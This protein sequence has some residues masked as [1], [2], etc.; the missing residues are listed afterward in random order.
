MCDIPYIHKSAGHFYQNQ[1][2]KDMSKTNL[3]F[4][5]IYEDILHI[6]IQIHIL[7]LSRYSLKQV[8]V[9]VDLQSIYKSIF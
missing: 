6:Y 9:Q 2:S 8:I 7:T 3:L 5:F 1:I 4:I